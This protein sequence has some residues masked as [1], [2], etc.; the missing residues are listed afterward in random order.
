M[1]QTLFLLF[2][3]SVAQLQITVIMSHSSLFKLV[4]SWKSSPRTASAP[5]TAWS[6]C[7][8]VQEANQFTSS[9]PDNLPMA[10][11]PEIQLKHHYQFYSCFLSLSWPPSWGS[12]STLTPSQFCYLLYRVSGSLTVPIPCVL[13]SEHC[14]K[15]LWIVHHPFSA[16][17][18]KRVQ[19]GLDTDIITR[20]VWAEHFCCYWQPFE[21][22]TSL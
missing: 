20:L 4:H 22:F 2:F 21:A 9:G 17:S 14:T 11:K 12:V 5:P 15:K 3:Q 18:C 13:K 8:D 19:R 6:P 1:C 10:S 7:C 16:W